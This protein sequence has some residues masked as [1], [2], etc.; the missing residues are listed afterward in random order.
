M[1]TEGGEFDA[2][3]YTGEDG[4]AAL[5]LRRGGGGRGG[6]DAAARDREEEGGRKNGVFGVHGEWE[7]VEGTRFESGQEFDPQVNWVSGSMT[8]VSYNGRWENGKF[9]KKKKNCLHFFIF[10][11]LLFN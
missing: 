6:D 5:W 10:L 2:G 8:I 9:K 4:P 3:E 11:A 1:S 7:N